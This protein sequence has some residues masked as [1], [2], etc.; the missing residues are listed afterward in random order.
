MYS[1]NEKMCTVTYANAMRMGA[2]EQWWAAKVGDK[3]K[4]CDAQLW[5]DYI[6]RNNE[7]VFQN[8]MANEVDPDCRQMMDSQA[9]RDYLAYLASLGD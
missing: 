6:T 4:E 7:R 2:D 3:T 8:V 5:H 1:Q 9:Y